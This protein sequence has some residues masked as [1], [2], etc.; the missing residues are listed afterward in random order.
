MVQENAEAKEGMK[1]RR[2][3]EASI[4]QREE[5]WARWMKEMTIPAPNIEGRLSERGNLSVCQAIS[6]CGCA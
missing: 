6:V 5:L 2:W 4:H 1:G 3:D